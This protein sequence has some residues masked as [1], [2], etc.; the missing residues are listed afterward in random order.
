LR[1]YATSLKVTDLRPGCGEVIETVYLILP[2][3]PYPGVY[4]ASNRNEYL[5]QKNN[6]SEQ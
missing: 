5:K 4:S 3:L 6:I 2:G 1:H